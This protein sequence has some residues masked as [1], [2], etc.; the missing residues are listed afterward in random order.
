VSVV[1]VFVVVDPV[2]SPFVPVVAVVVL[3]VTAVVVVVLVIGRVTVGTVT[4][5]TVVVM[6]PRTG[7]QT[8]RGAAGTALESAPATSNPAASSTG[9]ATAQRTGNRE[10]RWRRRRKN[11]MGRPC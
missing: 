2:V 9:P 8:S 6:Q 11:L 5:G 10:M 7:R 3:V 1:V 4:V